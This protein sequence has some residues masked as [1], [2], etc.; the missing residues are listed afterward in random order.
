MGNPHSKGLNKG[1]SD[2]RK[3]QSKNTKKSTKK[4]HLISSKGKNRDA[5]KH[6]NNKSLIKQI[7]D[8]DIKTRSKLNI[9]ALIYFLPFSFLREPYP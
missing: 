7:K 4:L 2:Q 5:V 6:A 8:P 3:C 1:S 9:M